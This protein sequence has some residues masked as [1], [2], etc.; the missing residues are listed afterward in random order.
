M[1]Y[2]IIA[3][4]HLAYSDSN[5]LFIV[6]KFMQEGTNCFFRKT[7][8]VRFYRPLNQFIDGTPIQVCD[9]LIERGSKEIICGTPWLE[10]S[11]CGIAQE[12][13]DKH[14]QHGG[15]IKPVI[16]TEHQ[17]TVLEEK[18]KIEHS[19]G[20]D[21]TIADLTTPFNLLKDMTH[22]FFIEPL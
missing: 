1:I 3:D 18:N 22:V 2:S 11:S 4:F 7:L 16:K 9:K 8:P 6:V 10:N 17:T 21:D 13:P 20:L 5:R 19:S 14:S 15:G 12:Q